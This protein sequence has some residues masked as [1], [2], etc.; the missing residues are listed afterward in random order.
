MSDVT[1]AF[2]PSLDPRGEPDRGILPA[3]ENLA[4]HADDGLP[5]DHQGARMPQAE[6]R[7]ISVEDAL[8]LLHDAGLDVA[9]GLRVLRGKTETYL[10]LMRQFILSHADDM[11]AVHS[12]L[13]KGE[14]HQAVALAHALKGAAAT[15]GAGRIAEI[16]RELELAAPHVTLGDCSLRP[17]LDAIRA[18]FAAIAAALPPT[19]V[20]SPVEAVADTDPA[21]LKNVFNALDTALAQGGLGAAGLLKEYGGLLR[22]GL[23]SEFEPLARRVA[24][25]DFDQARATLHALRH[26][27]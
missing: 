9:Q 10:G 12:C 11:N 23:G 14:R 7:P 24:E 22:A 25:F 3:T 5:P 6:P 17:R 13:G 21:K 26:R 8:E 20:A 15:L 2:M 4:D 18:E 19:V 1:I 27:R 16:A